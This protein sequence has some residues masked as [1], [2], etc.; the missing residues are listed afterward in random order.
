M[1]TSVKPKVTTAD[2]LYQLSSDGM[3]YELVEG[4]LR[5]MWPAGG[6]HGRLAIRIAWLL[7]NHVIANQLGVVLAAET[8]FRIS[9]NPDT[10]LAPDVAYVENSR[11]GQVENEVGYL[12]LA[13]DLAVEV[14]SPNDRF[15]RV[16][17]KALAWLDAGSKLVLL[18]DPEMETIHAYR[19]R[20][21]IQIF[22]KLE[23]IECGDA[24]PGWTLEVNDVFRQRF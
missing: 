1:P 14:L 5:M 19:S 2:E 3:R 20:S 11:Y 13:P 8:G 22:E 24:V 18:V 17:S 10:V 4:S 21:E 15:S 16:E 6:R 23:T 12:P 7:N 9:E